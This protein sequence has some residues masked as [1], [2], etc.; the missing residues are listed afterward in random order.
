VQLCCNAA[1]EEDVMNDTHAPGWQ[2]AGPADLAPAGLA[3][4]S[5]G[6]TRL[7]IARDDRGGWFALAAVCS[8]ALLPLDGARV[9][10]GALLCPHHGARF[11]LASGRAL[12]PP[13]STG[14]ATW[15]V[16]VAAGRVEVQL[17][18]ASAA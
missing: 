6:A 5:V 14:I 4:R 11:D 3:C 17:G 1:D 18:C 8:H 10:G 12:G 7:I 13:A 2:D 15:P 16:R 9:R